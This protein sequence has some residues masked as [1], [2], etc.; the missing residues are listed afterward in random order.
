MV[1]RRQLGTLRKA[2]IGPG[3]V[4]IDDK[5]TKLKEASQIGSLGSSS[6]LAQ[7]TC[8]RE[9]SSID[10]SHVPL[11]GRKQE[12]VCVFAQVWRMGGFLLSDSECFHAVGPS[13]RSNTAQHLLP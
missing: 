2:S 13:R 8:A 9:T 4:S 10:S 5:V 11:R 3:E 6:D 7:H 1:R 12:E